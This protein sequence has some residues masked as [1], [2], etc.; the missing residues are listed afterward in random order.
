MK[1]D[2]TWQYVTLQGKRIMHSLLPGILLLLSTA[3][4]A[5]QLDKKISVQFKNTSLRE[6]CATIEKLSGYNFSY[7]ENNL[8][9][10]DKKITLSLSDAPVKT[11][12]DRIFQKSPLTY[13]AKGNLL[14][15][16][17]DPAWQKTQ[18]PF[19]KAPGKVTGR[20]MD[21][22]NGQ[23][24]TGATIR[25][26]DRSTTSNL[27]GTFS[28]SL[29]EGNYKAT[30]SYVGYGTKEITAIEV[31]NNQPIELNI[32]L[33]RAKGQLQQVV[34]TAS[35]RQESVASL[36]ARQKNN[37]AV[38]DGISAEQ[39]RLTPDNNA[40][41]VLKRINGLTVQDDKFVTVRGLSERYNNVLLNG[42]SLPSTEPNRRNFAF[43]VIPSGLIENIV[44][45]KTAT[46][47]MPSEFAGGLVQV[48]TRSIPDRNFFTLTAGTGINTNSTGKSLYGTKRGGN[49][50]L[51]FDDGTRGWWNNTW[52]TNEYRQYIATG[53]KAKRSEM[54][55]RIPNNFG[56]HKYA[57]APMQ[58][59]QLAAGR[60][61]DLKDNVSSFGITVA[62]TY[63]HEEN[64]V[65]ETRYYPS[66]FK[67]DSARSYLFNTAL[68]AVLNVGFQT[69]GHK[70]S[71]RNLY[72]R[73]F[74][75]ESNVYYGLSWHTISGPVKYYIDVTLINSL[76]QNRLEGEHLLPKGIRFDWSFD[77][78]VLERDQPDTRSSNGYT[79]KGPKGQYRKYVLNDQQW[80]LQ[81]GI[82]IFNARLKER[83]KNAAAN[84]TIPFK[85]GG[86]AQS[87]KT[88]YAGTFRNADYKSLA[89]RTF[90]AHQSGSVIDTIE[91]AV[92]GMADYELHTPTFLKPDML[93]YRPT[94][95]GGQ[96]FSG[97]DYTGEQQ[98]HAAYLMAD[99]RFLNRFRFIGGVRMEQ[100][101]MKV[102]GIFYPQPAGVP[103]DTLATY[104]AGNWLPSL[105][106]IY[107]L[108]S[109]MNLRAAYSQTLARP[110]FRERA[111]YTYYEFKER[112]TYKGAIGLQDA[113]VHNYDL[114]YEYYPE[115]GEV[116]SFSLFYK[117]FENPVELVGAF[118]GKD[119]NLFY[120][121]LQNSTSKG[122][123]LDLRKSLS[124]IH[125]GVPWLKRI[126]VSANAA[127]MEANVKYNTL[128]LQN[129]ANSVTTAPNDAVNADSRNR[130]LQ[131]LSPYVVN[132]SIGYFGNIIGLNIS[133]NRYGRRIVVAGYQPWQDQ[134]ENPRDVIDLQLSANL[135]KKRIQVRCN[136]SDLLQQKNIIYQNQSLVPIP[137]SGPDSD[138]HNLGGASDNDPKGNGFNKNLDFAR[139][140]WFKGRNLSLSITYSL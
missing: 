105:N 43:D 37:A 68:G 81:E 7:A 21:E 130:P 132:G 19:S 54:D 125:R 100:S 98:V 27:D 85:V 121:N 42:A 44:V 59:Y 96:G 108:T 64:V 83:R 41:Q 28:I 3:A 13:T 17:P 23:P 134:Y 135:F 115:A 122:F 90:F 31:H 102:K 48:N 66:Y 53:N 69:K 51:G 1:K 89:L 70:I 120:F 22:E 24:V 36:Y 25:I 16:T 95:S 15:L 9:A 128:A 2:R 113:Q 65:D 92:F 76:L 20:I 88:G 56:L 12:L 38:S 57:Y 84:F 35:A 32:T 124:F 82:N 11:V 97:D 101:I 5:Q 93:E 104:R 26:G 72:N 71:L 34:V 112:A 4:S 79:D 106:L 67:Y 118:G 86:V 30:I 91:K 139:H 6:A 137:S 129:A 111:P 117:R 114:R 73:R 8:L 78:I 126:Y 62:A 61:I 14:F 109:K 10:Y 75:N 99:L 80:F 39:I 74:S 40:A 46:P 77:N 94:G 116:I 127:W 140:S 131:G 60:K 58:Q 29:P 103:R 63:R 138:T 87:L 52:N 50:R 18:A 133:Y 136:V 49:D 33:K 107:Q 119:A 123:E 55:Q 45:N 47:D 110:D